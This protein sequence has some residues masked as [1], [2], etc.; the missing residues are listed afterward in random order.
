MERTFPFD[1]QALS[2]NK[3]ILITETIDNIY[4]CQLASDIDYQA[5]A[6]LCRRYDRSIVTVEDFVEFHPITETI[7]PEIVSL[8]STL[9]ADCLLAES[10][11]TAV[12]GG[13]NLLEFSRP[14]TTSA[15]L[16]AVLKRPDTLK[17]SVGSQAIFVY[18]IRS[19]DT[20]GGLAHIKRRGGLFTPEKR[21]RA[22]P[23]ASV[24][25]KAASAKVRR[26]FLWRW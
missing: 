21:K 7:V 11:Q 2:S 20:K 24:A 5:L 16:D 12:S 8:P 25:G 3:Q 17:V 6:E 14:R 4:R 13:I 26:K 10:L 23:R 15:V 1:L 19:N 22:W 18:Q 9:S